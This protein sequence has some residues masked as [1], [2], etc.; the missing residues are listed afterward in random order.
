MEEKRIKKI[1]L[2]EN[3]FLEIYDASK[4]LAGDRWQVLMVARIKLSVSETLM[5]AGDQLAEELDDLK[6][7]LEK[8]VVFEQK[9][10]RI[11]IASSEKDKIFD[12]LL[13]GFIKT[14]LPY[15]S[16]PE[17][18][19]RFVYKKYREAKEKENWYH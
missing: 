16:R 5:A 15:L 7:V 4:K 1:E 3:I 12:E 18:P 9:S 10:K 17:F 8:T 2:G 19:R 6:A 13:N 11:F 14:S